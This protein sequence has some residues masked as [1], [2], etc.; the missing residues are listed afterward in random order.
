MTSQSAPAVGA[1]P[2]GSASTGPVPRFD[3][4]VVV[5]E[6]NRAYSQIIGDPAAPYLNSL[7]AG[8]ALFTRS[9]GLTHPSQPNYLA[10][11]SGSTQGV[12]GDSCPHSFAGPNLGSQLIGAG[13]GFAGYSESMASDG[14]LGCSSDSYARKHN[15]W[16]DF[17]NLPATVNRTLDAFPADYATLPTVS[18][19]IPNLD[20]D[21]HDGSV[22]TGDGWLKAHLDGYAQWAK[23]HHSLLIVTWDENDNSPGNHIATILYGQSVR[24]GRYAERVSHYRLL[25]TLQTGY[26]LPGL[27]DSATASPITDVWQ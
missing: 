26:G 18:F 15:P 6:E 21:M 9:Y 8:G 19:V 5:V 3:H 1:S 25:R 11:F 24:T 10:L 7:A 22:A 14:F 20:H 12:A 2:S 23:T 27:G 13:L 17:A 16:S 4:V